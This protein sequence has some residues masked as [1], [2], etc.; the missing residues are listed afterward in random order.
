MK[1]T[2]KI[3]K[4]VGTII[5]SIFII[6]LFVLLFYN[7]ININGKKEYLD[8]LGYKMFIVKDYQEQSTIKKDTIIITNTSQIQVNDIVALRI[9]NGIYFHTI[10]KIIGNE[11]YITKSLD[12]YNDDQGVFTNEEI[13]GKVVKQIPWFGKILNI[14]TT[15]TFSVIILAVL[16]L[17]FKHNKRKHIKM[18]KRRLKQKSFENNNIINKKN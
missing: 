17:V 9:N 12:N 1:K 16:I 10:E 5:K 8:I 13:E 2:L 4:V 6:I 18:N 7:I 3:S 14:V 15:K 11:N